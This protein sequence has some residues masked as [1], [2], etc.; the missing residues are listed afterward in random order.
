MSDNAAVTERNA[1][2]LKFQEQT[3]N[4]YNLLYTTVDTENKRISKSFNKMLDAHLADGQKSK[5]MNQSGD[6]I[7]KIYGYLFW[8]YYIC[9]IILTILLYFQPFSIY[10]KVFIVL[11]MF[12]FPFYI[13]HIEEWIYV[14][15]DYIWHILVSQ[16]Y[17][18]GF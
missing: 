2:I 4:N 15:S 11:L 12:G 13:Y 7:L 5:Y 16:V 9:I 14:Y 8:I 1:R 3:L 18:N 17:S 10:L 6:I